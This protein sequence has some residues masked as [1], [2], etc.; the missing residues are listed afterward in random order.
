MNKECVVQ[1][2]QHIRDNQY[3]G[4]KTDNFPIGER[5]IYA[6]DKGLIDRSIN[7]NF[8]VTEKGAELLEEKVNWES[9]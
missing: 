8:I 7:G 1:M 3:L 4:P 9:L 6:L 5:V 2:L